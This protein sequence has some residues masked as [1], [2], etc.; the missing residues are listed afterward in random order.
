MKEHWKKIKRFENY[1]ISNFGR[2]RKLDFEVEVIRNGKKF[3]R[4]YKGH[5]LKP[6]ISTVGYEIVILKNSNDYRL[7]SIHRLV[8]E[9][10]IPNPNNLSD[11]NHK[12]ENKLNNRVDNLEWLSHKDNMNYGNRVDK[13]R[14]TRIK[15]WTMN[16]TDDMRIIDKM[17]NGQIELFRDVEEIVYIYEGKEYGSR[18]EWCGENNKTPAR[19]CQL[20]KLGEIEIKKYITRQPKCYKKTLY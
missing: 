8:A 4:K 13:L 11:V 15:N 3:I 14:E 20:I 16:K 19:M 5:I 18:I 2:I 6:S 1:E 9:H 10:F 12:D 7:T 17:I